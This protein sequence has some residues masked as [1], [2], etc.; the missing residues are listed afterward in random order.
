V[1]ELHFGARI[2]VLQ[3]VEDRGEE[4]VSIYKPDIA[5]K[6]T[7]TVPVRNTS[8][9]ALA[10]ACAG[11]AKAGISPSATVDLEGDTR[12]ISGGNLVA[13]WTE[14]IPGERIQ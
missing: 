8:L 4:L 11:L 6:R 13:E 10:D 3:L 2:L 12:G 5:V 14:V 7:A 1:A 9:G